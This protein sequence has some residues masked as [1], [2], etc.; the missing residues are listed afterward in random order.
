MGDAEI[1]AAAAGKDFTTNRAIH[2]VGIP[3]GLLLGKIDA[4]LHRPTGVY[5]VETGEQGLAHGHHADEII[6]DRTQFFLTAR[7]IEAVAVGFAI[8]R[9]HP[10]CPA[11]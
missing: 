1:H 5:R 2:R 11:D 7:C 6:E 9:T 4:D 3:L 10:Q 8:G